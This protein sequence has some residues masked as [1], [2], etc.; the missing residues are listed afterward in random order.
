LGANIG[1]RKIM[2][3]E[4]NQYVKAENDPHDQIMRFYQ[5]YKEEPFLD[6]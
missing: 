3:F 5:D 2:Q 4:D 6:D 1:Y